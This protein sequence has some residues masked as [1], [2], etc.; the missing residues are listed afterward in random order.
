M[1][2]LARNTIFFY[3]LFP[4]LLWWGN[5]LFAQTA[6][7]IKFKRISQ[8][9][10]LSQNSVLC[11]LQDRQGF[12]WFGTEI[13]LNKYDGYAFTT[14]KKDPQDLNSLSDDYISS[15]CEDRSGLLWIGTSGGL[16]SL[17]PH[18]E[19]IKHFQYSPNNPNSLSNNIV[20][21]VY[22]DRAGVLWIGTNGGLNRL[23]K[24][25]GIFIHYQHDPN[26]PQSLSE[27]EVKCI[28]EDRSGVLWIGT[29]GGGLNRMNRETE[30]FE[31]FIHQADKPNSISGNDVNVLFEDQNDALWIGTDE[32]GL[33]S[34]DR[35]TETF[36]HY[37]RQTDAP[38]EIS[39][40]KI[41]AIYEDRLGDLWIGTWGGGL[42]RFDRKSNRFFHYRHDSRDPFS[43]SDNE[44]MAIY[45]DQSGAIWVGA[46]SGGLNR[47]SPEPNPFL[48]YRRRADDANSLSGNHVKSIFEDRSGMLWIGVWGNGLNRFD[49]NTQTFT[50]YA[51]QP[52]KVNSLSGKD[53][54]VVF[55]DSRERLWIGTDDGELDRLDKNREKLR[56]FRRDRN[57]PFSLS[58][59]EVRS[60]YQDREGNLWI[61]T[62]GGGLNLFDETQEQFIRFEYDLNDSNSISSDRV[63]SIIED[64]EGELW[65]GTWGGGLNKLD[66]K[67]SAF[68]RFQ[69]D[70]TDPT[71]LN[72]DFVTCLYV[73]QKD[74]LWIGTRSGGL[75]KLMKTDEGLIEFQQIR[76]E[77]GL[78]NNAIMGILEDEKGDL[79]ISTI[80]GLNRLDLATGNIH[81][82]DV[83]D[84]LQSNQFDNAFC[85]S[86]NG[87]LLFGGVNGFNIFLPEAVKD[88]PY[89]PPVVITRLRRWQ[90]IKGEYV[91]IEDRNISTKSAVVL[92]YKSKILEFEFAALSYRNSFKNQ[93]AYQLEGLNEDWIYQN[94]KRDVQFTNLSPGDYILKI[95]ASNDHEVWNEA[96]TT[97]KITILPPWWR[98]TIAFFL[99]GVSFLAIFYGLYRFQLNRK[100]AENE[101]KRLRE[102]DAF[103]SRFYTNITHEF[104]TPLT[105]ILG[106]LNAFKDSKQTHH[107]K[108]IA[109]I[110][111]NGTGLL[112]LIN[113]MLD[114]SKLESGSMKLNLEQ[115]DIIGYISEI[116]ASFQPY[117]S[118]KDLQLFFN[119]KM[120]TCLMDFDR[121]KMWKILSNLLSNA[122]K[123]TPGGGQIF[124][125]ASVRPPIEGTP[126]E[127]LTVSVKDTGPGIEPETLPHIFDRFYQAGDLSEDHSF[128]KVKDP[129]RRQK[130]PTDNGT[131][132]A[133]A[134]LI[135]GTGIGLALTKELVHLMN[136]RIEAR[137]NP[138]QGA[139]FR[140]SFPI[141]RTAA[142]QKTVVASL[143]LNEM[144]AVSSGL[145]EQTEYLATSNKDAPLL[146]IIEDNR[147]LVQYLISCLEKDYR[148][149][150]AYNG[151]E[152]I[153]K[154]IDLTPDL[155]IS[156]VMMPKKNGFEV[157][158]T[159]KSD[160]RCS[161][162][163]I[164]LLTA[165]ADFASRLEGLERGADAYLPKPFQAEELLVRLKKLLELRRKL[166]RYYL[167]LAQQPTEVAEKPE[168]DPIEKADADFVQKVRT[169]VNK[170]L[171]NYDFNVK[172]LCRETAMSNTQ[173]H[174][175][176]SALTGYS[177]NRFIRYIRLSQ[178]KCL[179][180][181]TNESIVD[182]AYEVGF[183]DPNYFN[184]TF[185]KEFGMT[186]GEFRNDER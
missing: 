156:D 112:K 9:D 120:E 173:L 96:G 178:A 14:Y 5:L 152:G 131:I 45:E 49:P 28:Y 44:I 19:E 151:Q 64:S 113:Q 25:A 175:K 52:G 36:Q 4:L 10:G 122:L 39:D 79:W 90:N 24:N 42:N 93:Y 33:N 102:L 110:K 29:D 118:Q 169:I 51:H 132:Q 12:M 157:C 140:L 145:K 66:Q 99:Y 72:D 43:L 83:H 176:L 150:V 106:M 77:N 128:A 20:K 129:S 59:N 185:K 163:P 94:S 158:Q 78:S 87:A 61:G 85:K 40:D 153:D 162:I 58:D 13:G 123:F 46:W 88:N 105:I 65:I 164:V 56:H 144:S 115:S 11:I 167:Q 125:E 161:H 171:A 111:R 17:N 108:A 141:R 92:P 7:P 70:L 2:I 23:D 71:T 166:Q 75:N 89:F 147:D 117:A 101:A 67:K 170:H 41:R 37:R 3:L 184:R 165:K 116:I 22:E 98:T 104:R 34:F 121:D 62:W 180:R 168:S 38:Y 126:T 135:P 133:A 26:D 137:N 50:H 143:P 1:R 174:R 177:A 27:N 48:H 134:A 15:I 57:D 114:L 84:G 100:L 53:V 86:K 127:E 6:P 148:L 21:V 63:T 146:L 149:E 68:Q 81:H 47:F 179:L 54:N 30:K 8:E 159:L 74:F 181:D 124:V 97:L 31:S 155:I 142:L 16:N 91:A 60:I 139:E 183:K 160:E 73:D 76:T 69:H 95:K 82:Y 80:N 18:T 32:D 119:K 172:Q 130:T 154:A 107:K 109:M 136:G 35:R 182:I 55:E 138:D 186:P 103:K